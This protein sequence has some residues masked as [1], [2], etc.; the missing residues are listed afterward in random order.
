MLNHTVIIVHLSRPWA[1]FHRRYML[2]ALARALP[3]GVAMLCV[4]RP[5][6]L[7][8]TWW[9]HPSRFFRS[10]WRV[11]CRAEAP[12]LYVAD[13]RTLLHDFILFRVPWMSRLNAMTLSP[14][15]RRIVRGLARAIRLLPNG[16]P[17]SFL[18][19]PPFLG[20]PI[21]EIPLPRVGYVGVI[22]RPMN[23]AMLRAVFAERRDWHLVLVGPVHQDSGVTVLR[24]LP[25]V[26]LVGPRPFESL[27]AIMRKLDVGIIPHQINA[28]SRVFRPLKLCE[29]LGRGVPVAATRLPEL[30]GL[31]RF[32]S[33]SDETMSSFT[34]AIESALERRSAQFEREAKEWA[35]DYPWDRIAER[36]I[37]PVLRVVFGT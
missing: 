10:V 31:E 23:M 24:D 36:D 6:T 21:D 27:P 12:N 33:L 29:Y 9:R 35:Q 32:V 25:N 26:H 18:E 22:R 1:I 14:Q 19:R 5:I 17:D 37:I 15:L 28:F 13:V 8:V 7:D 3:D 30:Q 16:I 20:D 11:S 2:L 4:D 34:S